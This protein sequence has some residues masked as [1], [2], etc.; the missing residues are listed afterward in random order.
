METQDILFYTG[1]ALLITVTLI[2]V[3][4]FT[5]LYKYHK[6]QKRCSDVKIACAGSGASE[7]PVE[8]KIRNSALVRVQALINSQERPELYTSYLVKGNSMQYANLKPNDILIAKHQDI[9]EAEDSF[10]AIVVI[11]RDDARRGECMYK[12]R[13]AWSIV[14]EN[15]A[16]DQFGR[17]VDTILTSRQF[18]DL[19][20]RAQEKCPS[21]EELKFEVM[22]SFRVYDRDGEVLLSTTYKTD[23]ERIH[24]SLHSLS[25]VVGLGEYVSAAPKEN[26]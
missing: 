24:F 22:N 20:E 18:A 21:D 4:N 10:P 14:K 5:K 19:R 25:S 13:R 11:S 2:L 8:E 7:Y 26:D 3:V 1:C 9:H 6:F 15:M 16:E 17:I 23:R 12:I